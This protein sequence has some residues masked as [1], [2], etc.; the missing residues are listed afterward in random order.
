MKKPITE[1]DVEENVLDTPKSMDHDVTGGSLEQYLADNGY[2]PLSKSWIIRM[3]VLDILNGYSYINR[4]L[5]KQDKKQLNDD[6]KALYKASLAWDIN[7]PINV[8]ESG[9]LL[10]F[11]QFASWKYKLNKK[12]I[13]EGTLKTRLIWNDPDIVN[14]SLEKLI[15]MYNKKE[16]ESSQ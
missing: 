13:K 7:L 14:F 5:E 16:L 3:G 11:L 4:F 8:G 9:T 1:E 10:R 15:E 6:L 12:F 2:I